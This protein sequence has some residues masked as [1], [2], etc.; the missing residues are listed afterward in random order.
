MRGNEQF[1]ATDGSWKINFCMLEAYVQ[2]VV[3]NV[4]VIWIESKRSEYSKDLQRNIL[5]QRKSNFV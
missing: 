3:I 2:W 4:K 1:L 5:K